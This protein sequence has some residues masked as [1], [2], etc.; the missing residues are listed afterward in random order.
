MFRQICTNRRNC[1]A[2][3]L[4]CR[5][6][7]PALCA[8]VLINLGMGARAQESNS[9]DL[10][11]FDQQSNSSAPNASASNAADLTRFDPLNA[12][13]WVI[14]HPSVADTLVGDAG[15]VRSALADAGI[16]FCGISSNIFEYDLTQANLGKPISVNGQGGT[17]N[18]A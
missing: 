3:E 14:P 13:G 6:V 9:S 16:G 8:C 18:V 2:F 10:N 12:R 17:W 15:G 11:S 4:F 1:T 5:F 7:G